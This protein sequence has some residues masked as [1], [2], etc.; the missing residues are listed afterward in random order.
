[1]P[2][3]NAEKQRAYR[4]RRAAQEFIPTEER[5]QWAE[6]QLEQLRRLIGNKAFQAVHETLYAFVLADDQN[7]A[8]HALAYFARG[9]HGV[10]YRQVKEQSARTVHPLHSPALPVT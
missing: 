8:R 6:A 1:M 2:M 3:T 4:R 5:D 9:I 7:V 10:H